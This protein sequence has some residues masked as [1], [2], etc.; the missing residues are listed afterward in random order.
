MSPKSAGAT[1]APCPG[2]KKRGKH[3]HTK[4][5]TPKSRVS[6]K[7][8]V[9]AKKNECRLTALSPKCRVKHT[10]MHALNETVREAYRLAPGAARKELRRY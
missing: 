4:K 7:L 9:L 6:S 3:T 1:S 2:E 8:H 10:C 5:N